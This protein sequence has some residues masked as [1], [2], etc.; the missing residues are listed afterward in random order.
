MWEQWEQ[1]QMGK[2]T[3]GQPRLENLKP[4]TCTAVHIA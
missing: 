2:K 4:G 3:M 1:K